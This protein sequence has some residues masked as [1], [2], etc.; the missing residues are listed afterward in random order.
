MLLCLTQ[1]T[2]VTRL[3]GEDK[4]NR[5]SG[6]GVRGGKGGGEGER[7]EGAREEEEG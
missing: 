7:E 6:G 5:D 4:S 2:R 3:N 1:T